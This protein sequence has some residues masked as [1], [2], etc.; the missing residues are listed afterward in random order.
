MFTGIYM[1]QNKATNSQ[2]ADKVHVFT[3]SRDS[4]IYQIM[5]LP[6]ETVAFDHDIVGR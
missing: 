4:D 2:A 3:K 1:Y 5:R 6:T